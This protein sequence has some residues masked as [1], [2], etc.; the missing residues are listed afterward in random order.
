MNGPKSHQA[1][2]LETQKL[3][4]IGMKIYLAKKKG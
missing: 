2:Y 3:K 1:I 4:N